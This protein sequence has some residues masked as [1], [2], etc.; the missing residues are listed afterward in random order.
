MKKQVEIG[1][2]VTVILPKYYGQKGVVVSKVEGKALTYRVHLPHA[3]GVI[4]KGG[5]GVYIEI[6]RTHFIRKCEIPQ[7]NKLFKS[8]RSLIAMF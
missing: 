4:V 5:N 7:E 2:E 3:K 6:F 8:L 1:E